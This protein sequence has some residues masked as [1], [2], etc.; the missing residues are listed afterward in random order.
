MI[1]SKVKVKIGGFI[2]RFYCRLTL[3]MFKYGSHS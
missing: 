3:K 1:L 2:K